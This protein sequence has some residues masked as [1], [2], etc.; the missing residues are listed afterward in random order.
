[1]NKNLYRGKLFI[2]LSY[3]LMHEHSLYIKSIFSGIKIL[4]LT[5][6]SDSMYENDR[7]LDDLVTR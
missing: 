5:K 4:T 2:K 6:K 7:A 3:S 1:M